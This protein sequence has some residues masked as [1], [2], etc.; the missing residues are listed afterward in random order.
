MNAL[1][2]TAN[3]AFDSLRAHAKACAAVLIHFLAKAAQ[4]RMLQHLLYGI[5]QIPVACIP[6]R[7][8]HLLQIQP[9]QIIQTHF[10]TF[11]C[12][13]AQVD[14]LIEQLFHFIRLHHQAFGSGL[15]I[16]FPYAIVRGTGGHQDLRH[17]F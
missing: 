10:H 1:N 7:Q 5:A 2:G 6:H 4:G 11:R 16:L 3:A 15:Y 14:G 17:S 8:V 13:Q 12:V 9:D